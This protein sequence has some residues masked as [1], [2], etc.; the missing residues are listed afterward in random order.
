MKTHLKHICFSRFCGDVVNGYEIIQPEELVI[1]FG[2]EVINGA[3]NDISST[4]MVAWP[5][6]R[7]ASK[8]F[9]DIVVELNNINTFKHICFS[10]FCGDVVN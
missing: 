4:T 7:I 3:A 1:S 10:E 5:Y 6:F 2:F 8:I 9:T